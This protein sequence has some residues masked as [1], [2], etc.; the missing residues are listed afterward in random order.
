[1]T[2]LKET[3]E[4]CSLKVT[5]ELGI[6]SVPLL[7]QGGF[8]SSCSL[9]LD[10]A[11]AQNHTGSSLEVKNTEV[12]KG[13]LPK[14]NPHCGSS[15]GTRLGTQGWHKGHGAGTR[16]MGVVMVRLRDNVRDTVLAQGTQGWHKRHG[17][18]TRDMGASTG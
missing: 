5:L 9:N 16:D 6:F 4:V 18:G 13:E 10:S 2:A 1:M 14:V 17:D 8:T 3:S 12:K 15:T 11:I 7:L